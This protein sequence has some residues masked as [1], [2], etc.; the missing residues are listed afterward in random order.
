MEAYA[1]YLER[2]R[3]VRLVRKSGMLRVT[4]GCSAYIEAIAISKGERHSTTVNRASAVRCHIDPVLGKEPFGALTHVRVADFLEDLQVE[5]RGSGVTGQQGAGIETKRFV[6]GTLRSV[7]KYCYRGEPCPWGASPLVD[8]DAWQRP[9]DAARSG[10]PRGGADAS[11]GA[12]HAHT[13]RP[14]VRWPD[15]R[16]PPRRLW[17]WPARR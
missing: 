6:L 1:V 13:L 4:E 5:A 11:P 2:D 14:A 16:R 17:G 12:P 8:G 10:E 9:M 15:G 7:W 3:R